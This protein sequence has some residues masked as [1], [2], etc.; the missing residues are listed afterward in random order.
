MSSVII[1]PPNNVRCGCHMLHA[2]SGVLHRVYSLLL[3][4]LQSTCSMQCRL[5]TAV[6]CRARRHARRDSPPRSARSGSR[7]RTVASRSRVRPRVSLA[8]PVSTKPCAR[9]ARSTLGESTADTGDM[10]TWQVPQRTQTE[11]DRTQHT[12]THTHTHTVTH[13]IYASIYFRHTMHPPPLFH[14]DGVHN[15]TSHTHTH[16]AHSLKS[17]PQR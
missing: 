6:V 3:G 11:R 12:H 13:T 10:A 16:T 7:D 14:H 15:Y 9:T 8:L 1:N 2:M 17:K 5:T 4:S